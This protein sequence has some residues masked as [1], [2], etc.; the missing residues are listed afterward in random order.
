MNR[1][2]LVL[3]HL[4]LVHHYARKYASTD[5]SRDDLVGAGMVGLVEAAD[6]HDPE[7]GDNFASYAGHWIRCRMHEYA[8]AH[9]GRSRDGTIADDRDDPAAYWPASHV[10]GPDELYETAELSAK[11]RRA[12]GT[13][14]GKKRREIIKRRYLA[15]RPKMRPIADVGRSLR[16]RHDTASNLEASALR[17]LRV[18]LGVAA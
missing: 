16:I 8:K 5:V 18:E 10:P 1:D 12:V 2:E 15:D 7:R 13:M 11:V 9:Y 3:C 6:R 4:G 14:Q 17:W